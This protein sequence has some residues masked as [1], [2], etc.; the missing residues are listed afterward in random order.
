MQQNEKLT[1]LVSQSG[2]GSADIRQCVEQADGVEQPPLDRKVAVI[3]DECGK[4]TIKPWRHL[5]PPRTRCRSKTKRLILKL[6]VILRCPL[7]YLDSSRISFRLRGTCLSQYSSNS[8][9]FR[10]ADRIA[11]ISSGEK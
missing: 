7:N 6:D 5:R 2:K 1:G 4:N 3:A 10:A 9:R 8:G 11:S